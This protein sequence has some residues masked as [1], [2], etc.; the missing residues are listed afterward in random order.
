[1]ESGIN[2]LTCL[3][4]QLKYLPRMSL[5]FNFKPEMEGLCDH[6]VGLSRFFVDP[7]AVERIN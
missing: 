2:P 6:R 5:N 7:I 4:N 1:M 3:R